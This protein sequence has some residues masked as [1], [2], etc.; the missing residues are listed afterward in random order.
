MRYQGPAPSADTPACTGVLLTN[1][2]TPDSP[3]VGDVRRYLRQFLSD[4]R[5]VEVPRPIWWLILN[6]IIL[7][8]RPSRSAESYRQ[9]W[10][11]QGSPL[12]HFSRAQAEGLQRALD[13]AQ[14]RRPL[15]VELAMRYGQP[16]IAAG[17]ERLRRANAQRIVVLPLYPQYSATTSASTW[18]EVGRVLRG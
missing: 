7:R 2:G 13:E 6:G 11:E 3:S 8:F 1:L 10:S 5:V 16:S 18:D 4:P 12:L 9:V 14:S 15:R 17:L